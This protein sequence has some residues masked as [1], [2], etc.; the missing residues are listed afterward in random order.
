MIK[1]KFDI[2][3]HEILNTWADSITKKDNGFYAIVFSD[4]FSFDNC[5][6]FDNKLKCFR[7][8]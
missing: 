2:G 6:E 8:I 4:N 5:T 3:D 1:I 7:G